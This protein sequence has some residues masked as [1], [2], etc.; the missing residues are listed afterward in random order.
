MGIALPCGTNTS[1]QR[2]RQELS[3]Y[4]D[5]IPFHT[6]FELLKTGMK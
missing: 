5:Q 4:T 2:E 3:N 6:P 1:S